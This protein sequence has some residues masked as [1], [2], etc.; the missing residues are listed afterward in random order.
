MKRKNVSLR[1]KITPHFMLNVQK[2]ENWIREI[3]VGGAPA[4]RARRTGGGE[5]RFSAALGRCHSL[6]EP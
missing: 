5:Q 1:C 6:S 3:S 2:Y 4:G